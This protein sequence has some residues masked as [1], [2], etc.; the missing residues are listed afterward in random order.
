MSVEGMKEIT[1]HGGAPLPTGGSTCL[2]ATDAWISHASDRG[3]RRRTTSVQTSAEPRNCAS[4]SS[5]C[6]ATI[7]AIPRSIDAS[8]RMLVKE[9]LSP[10]GATVV[11]LIRSSVDHMSELIDNVLDTARG[12]WQVGCR[13][14]ATQGGTKGSGPDRCYRHSA[15]LKRP[16]CPGRRSPESSGT[17]SRG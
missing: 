15:F 13:G 5:P 9:F 12:A 8:A 17:A 3:Q 7:C 11:G 1:R 10:K 6:L 4:R 2:S 14:R 16:R